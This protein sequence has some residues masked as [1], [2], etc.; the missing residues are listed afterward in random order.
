MGL[1]SL[2][3][4]EKDAFEFFQ[5]KSLLPRHLNGKNGHKENIHRQK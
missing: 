3:N 5:E 1:W 4:S 2:P